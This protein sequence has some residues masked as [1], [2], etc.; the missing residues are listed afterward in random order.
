MS[1]KEV[2]RALM[3]RRH[4]VFL[5]PESPLDA[6]MIAELEH[7]KPY[8]VD[9]SHP[10]KLG[11]LRL[12]FGM[13]KLVM[14]NLPGFAPDVETLHEAV[15][16]MLGRTVLVDDVILPASISF[17]KMDEAEFR[18]YLDD[19]KV[20]LTQRLIPGASGDAFERQAMEMLGLTPMAVLEEMAT[21][22]APSAAPA[23]EPA[24]DFGA[25]DDDN[26]FGEPEPGQEPD[27]APPMTR[28]VRELAERRA[29]TGG[30]RELPPGLTRSEAEIWLHYY[31]ETIALM[32]ARRPPAGFT[33]PPHDPET[34]EVIESPQTPPSDART[35]EAPKD[36]SGSAMT[37]STDS[38]AETSGQPP[39]AKP[40]RGGKRGRRGESASE[41]QP[42]PDAPEPP[43]EAAPAASD[44]GTAA[45]TRGTGEPTSE[46][47]QRQ[48]EQSGAGAR[49]AASTGATAASVDAAAPASS[50]PSSS[51][52]PEFPSDDRRELWTLMNE[53]AP[54]PMDDLVQSK[55]AFELWMEYGAT[56]EA[57]VRDAWP[58]F[59]KSRAY[60]AAT[61]D[62]KAHLAGVMI[63]RRKELMR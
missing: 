19:F 5:A 29:R 26:P 39:L 2:E 50:L 6:E 16:I 17:A 24:S 49:S 33:L 36:T 51:A 53:P 28:E 3:V 20:L 48:G 18:R 35:A 57:E 58:A 45:G 7:G 27:E 30:P 22:R 42:S 44:V 61:A 11:T 41:T 23:L 8:R 21:E 60:A 54:I 52:L 4:G 62:E 55:D 47:E 59:W 56:R 14:N 32:R 43:A 46:G 63:R 25:E 12:Y 15:K 1:D 13:L 34:G 38:A 37:A 9:I 31:D 10:R 40:S